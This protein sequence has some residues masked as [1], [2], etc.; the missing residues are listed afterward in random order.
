MH[1]ELIL[2]SKML[3]GEAVA[4]RCAHWDTVLYPVALLQVVVGMRTMEVRA[5]VSETLSV[6][7]LLGTDVPELPDRLR[8]DASADAM[9]V[10]TQDERH[11]MLTEE[12]ETHQKK[13]ELGASNTGVD[14]VGEWMSS[15]DDDLF[16]G[17]QTRTRQSRAQKRAD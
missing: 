1:Q 14:E 13:V 17:G 15:L 10:V 8:T 9:A 5:A 6:D 2:R 16:G 12:E 4:I 3:D 7:V 11:Q